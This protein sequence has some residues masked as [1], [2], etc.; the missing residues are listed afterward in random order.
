MSL[1]HGDPLS[2]GIPVKFNIDPG[3]E[4]TAGNYLLEVLIVDQ[5]AGKNNTAAQ[6]VAIELVE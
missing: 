2:N 3:R 1:L 5:L 4:L 6:S